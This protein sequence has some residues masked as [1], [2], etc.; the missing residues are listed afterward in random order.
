[1]S[2]RILKLLKAHERSWGLWEQQC[3]LCFA[4]WMLFFNP[5]RHSWLSLSPDSG[6]ERQQGSEFFHFYSFPA[7]RLKRTEWLCS[8]HSGQEFCVTVTLYG[9][10]LF[11]RTEDC[12][13][14]LYPINRCYQNSLAVFHRKMPPQKSVAF[15]ALQLR[16]TTS[17][18]IELDLLDFSPTSKTH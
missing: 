15:N 7:E 8:S 1:M 4:S 11:Q 18:S 12:L 2:L 9:V 13:Y 10:D 3:C 6:G 17:R 14:C 5:P 16:A